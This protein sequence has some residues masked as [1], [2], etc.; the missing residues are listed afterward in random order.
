LRKSIAC[1]YIIVPDKDVAEKISL[2][3]LNKS[4]VAC[5]NTFPVTSAYIWN[6]ELCQEGEFVVLG[7]TLTSK[8]A[9][10]EQEVLAIHPYDVPL[11]GSWA[12]EVNDG[13]FEW[14]EGSLVDKD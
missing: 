4:L 3:L 14:V 7:K 11:I 2:L 5:T 9:A 10:I 1:A 12:M 8:I 6:N 13:Y